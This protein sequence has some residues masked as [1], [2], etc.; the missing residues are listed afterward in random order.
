MPFGEEGAL[1]A[2]AITEKTNAG[3]NG[4]RD[5]ISGTPNTLIRC[6]QLF[7]FFRKFFRNK[8]PLDNS[9]PCSPHQKRLVDQLADAE[10]LLAHAAQTG[11][12]IDADVCEAVFNA[13]ATITDNTDKWDKQTAENVLSA[14]TSLSRQLKPVTAESLQICAERPFKWRMHF[15]RTVAIT[16]VPIIVIFS[17]ITF[18]TS[19]ISK[20]I[21]ADITRGNELTIKLGDQIRATETNQQAKIV[22]RDLQEFAGIMRAIFARAKQLK[23]FI[24]YTADRISSVIEVKSS[25]E[26][27]DLSEKEEEALQIQPGEADKPEA[28]K[29][30]IVSYQGVRSA[31][32][33][34]KEYITIFYG[35]MGSCILPILYAL[36]GT[37]ASLLR[38][39]AK[40]FKDR[41]LNIHETHTARYV[42][43]VIGGAVVGLFPNFSINQTPAVSPLAIA[44]LVGYA[45]ELFFSF[46]DSLV[47]TFTRP[48]NPAPETKATYSYRQVRNNTPF[49][50]TPLG[51]TQVLSAEAIIQGVGPA[52]G[53]I[54]P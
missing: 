19:G 6:N 15:C 16:L 39:I 36:L 3:G 1:M 52:K 7:R 5:S 38:S 46:L 44:F 34:V 10:R 53:N 24:I 26:L 22:P 43:A 8:V 17:L 51:Q 20:A 2:E 35:A 42:T 31:A 21:D 32:D 9:S 37:C 54:G 48:D 50:I 28:A 49:P 33:R 45:I 25:I 23:R 47:Q 40:N 30:L 13:R 14:L 18:I 11:I 12:E 29:K 27:P 41:T 4:L